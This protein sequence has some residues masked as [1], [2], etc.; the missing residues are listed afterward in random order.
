LISGAAAP[1][2]RLL[3][4]LEFHVSAETSIGGILLRDQGSRAGR[5]V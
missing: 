3:V 2:F 1:G 5:R 4:F